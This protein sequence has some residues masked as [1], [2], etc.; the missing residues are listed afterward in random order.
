MMKTQK[1]KDEEKTIS[2]CYC[3]IED[4]VG[5]KDGRRERDCRRLDGN[6]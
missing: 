6:E 3:M 5:S 2:Y 1:S 4:G